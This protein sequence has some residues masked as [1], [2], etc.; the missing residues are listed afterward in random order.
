MTDCSAGRPG[1][2]PVWN[3]PGLP[4]LSYRVGVHR[5]FLDAM[6][7][8]LPVTGDDHAPLEGLTTREPDDPSIALLDAWAVVADVLTFYQERIAD[9]G[10][11]RTA[12]E[13]ESLVRLGRLVGHRPRPALAAAA[14]L[15]YTL[16]PGTSCVVPAGSQ[17]KSEPEPGALPVVF[18]TG[19]DLTARDRVPRSPPPG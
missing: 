5:Q 18:E 10:F 4:A 15:A 17:V 13:H 6:L 14:H 19:E 16:D 8:R 3:R 7:A 2:A 9:E 11:L 1:P 12:A